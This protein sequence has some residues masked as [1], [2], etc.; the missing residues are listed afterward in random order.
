[1]LTPA[2]QVPISASF[3]PS[4]AAFQPQVG[5]VLQGVIQA[6]NE[7]LLLIAGQ[8]RVQV[9]ARGDLVP[10]QTVTAE[11]IARNAQDNSIQLRIMPQTAATATQPAA[12][13]AALADMAGAV[14]RAL[15]AVNLPENAGPLLPP[16]LPPTPEMA[17]AALLLFAIRAQMGQHIKQVVA[18]I[19]EAIQAGVPLRAETRA[20]AAL[21]NR[22]VASEPESFESVLRQWLNESAVPT[23]ARVAQALASGAPERLSALMQSDAR[24]ALAQAR[25]DTALAG[26][27]RARGELPGFQDALARVVDR[28]VASQMQNVRGIEIPY[29]VSEIPFAPGGHIRD[30]LVHFLPEG[31][32]T[33]EETGSDY[34]T[35]ALDLS[36]TRLGDLWV[37]LQAG[38]GECHCRMQASETAA[39]EALRGAAKELEAGLVQAG[40]AR[41]TI[42][43]AEWDGNR[44][45]ETAA[46]LQRHAG[47]QVSA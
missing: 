47:F 31:R 19:Q 12:A 20:A 33:H 26:Y 24:A 10:G 34:A 45:R 6:T 30:G 35:A 5:Q 43:I 9:P 2:S 44:L 39:V 18:R 1:M 27:L 37:T 38:G 11:V 16:Q 25:G 7:G 3:L 29:W 46:L 32:Q 36:T 22:L 15:G 28:L 42:Q 23:E 4:E 21:L 17:R 40:Y 41:A 14:L 13:P 8:V